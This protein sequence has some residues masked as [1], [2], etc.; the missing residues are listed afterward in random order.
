MK[1]VICSYLCLFTRGYMGQMM[2]F[3]WDNYGKRLTSPI[4]LEKTWKNCWNKWENCR[5]WLGNMCEN[6]G[7]DW[8]T[9][10]E[11]A[12][13]K[14]TNWR[15]QWVRRKMWKL[16]ENLEKH[17]G[18]ILNKCELEKLEETVGK[19]NDVR[20]GDL[21]CKKYGKQQIWRI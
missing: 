20:L 2:G 7:A 17:L 11:D 4:T 8:R 1:I 15:K 12:G 10:K 3:Q 21:T 18:K 16:I 13:K 9:L 14:W 6:T 5:T 19:K